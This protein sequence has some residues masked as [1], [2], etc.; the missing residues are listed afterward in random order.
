M[1]INTLTKI[2]IG[3][4]TI[5]IISVPSVMSISVSVNSS[6]TTP[7]KNV[8][9][10]GTTYNYLDSKIITPI[11]Y[12]DEFTGILNTTKWKWIREPVG[13][14]GIY[15]TYLSI[16]TSN[17][18]MY[19]AVNSPLLYTNITPDENLTIIM[20]ITTLPIMNYQGAS[21]VFYSNDTHWIRLQYAFDGVPRVTIC[22]KAGSGTQSCTAYSGSSPVGKP[23]Y[24]KFI[25]SG[26]SYIEYHSTDK[27][28]WVTSASKTISINPTAIGI[29]VMQAS[30]N[31]IIPIDI[32]YFVTNN[33]TASGNTTSF[34]NSGA[35]NVVN[36]TDLK[37]K[38]NF[39]ACTGN[40]TTGICDQYFG[41]F[42]VANLGVWNNQTLSITSLH[43]DYFVN[44]TLKDGN[45]TNS[46]QIYE[47][48]HYTSNQFIP[49]IPS[50]L[51]NTSGNFW[52]N[53]TWTSSAGYDTNSFN[54]SVNGTWTN[55]SAN[56]FYNNSGLPVHAWS[57]ISVYSYNSTGSGVMNATP[58]SQNTQLSNNPISISNISDTY[59]AT[60]GSALTIYPASSDLDSDTPTFANTTTKGT[61]YTNNGTFI[62][63]PQAGDSGTYDWQINVSDGYGSLAYK[64]F[65][66]SVNS[67]TPG[68]PLNLTAS[69]GNFWINHTWNTSVNTNS[70]NVSV[71]GTWT[72]GSANTFYNNS[73]LPVHAWSN[74]SVHGYNTSSS[75]LGSGTSLNTQLS[76][77]APTFSTSISSS[78]L[79][80]GQSV[81]ITSEITDLDNDTLMNVTV[82]ITFT[83]LGGNEVN[84]SMTNGTGNN[85][86][87]IYNPGTTGTYSI[88]HIYA[89]DTYTNAS[90]ATALTFVVSQA[91][92][93]GGGGGGGG[94]SGTII[95]TPK[96]ENVSSS[97]KLNISLTNLTNGA[98]PV[99]DVEA[100]NDCLTNNLF[101]SGTCTDA[102]LITITEKSN[103]YTLAG[104]WLGAFF[105]LWTLTLQN[106]KKRSF[107]YD[108]IIY[109]IV[110]IVASL[111]ISLAGVN[112]MFL[113][114]FLANNTLSAYT[115]FTLTT[116]GF[117]VTYILDEITA[118]QQWKTRKIP[119]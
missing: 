118:K 106:N 44:I 82:G 74:I 116:Y 18:D 95:I 39:S 4:L 12:G 108:P 68:A 117:I 87:Y 93:G 16:N 14:W 98:R 11:G 62:W 90:T 81:T 83:S 103:W 38:G 30:D 80:L 32:D 41:D 66:V 101:L 104:A 27:I 5:L 56:T 114:N 112:V 10:D 119:I 6:T 60:I 55:G 31:P 26:S 48:I 102:T 51:A 45:Q 96:P 29:T 49:P 65:S 75:T 77:N 58:V 63:T 105:A 61:F 109:A 13:A 40:N 64:N 111:I 37:I 73:G 47:I 33:F 35:G 9:F 71:N 110:T 52:V 36:K 79:T 17:T 43:Q 1:K 24:I 3:F 2:I 94:G 97:S 42:T 76:N 86:T 54:V 53:H 28:T 69:S 57:N 89:N 15:P 70:F 50:N 59:T 25:K 99:S 92:G 34:H 19:S 46:S 67:T 91:S 88:S 115:F 8:T 22:S 113:G 85:W 72:N 78:A 100:I 20:N 21:I 7:W 107:I 84:Y 23:T